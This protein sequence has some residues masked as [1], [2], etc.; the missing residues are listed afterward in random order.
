MFIF[1]TYV[2]SMYAQLITRNIFCD[3]TTFSVCV[4]LLCLSAES[5]IAQK[6]VVHIRAIQEHMV[7]TSYSM[8]FQCE[9]SAAILELLAAVLEHLYFV[10]F[11]MKALVQLLPLDDNPGILAKI[12]CQLV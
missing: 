3:T 2:V 5:F 4:I 6:T 7:S 11:S 8:L 10:Q 1:L 12:Q 9:P